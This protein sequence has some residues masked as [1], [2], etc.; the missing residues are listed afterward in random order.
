MGCE[1]LRV[2]GRPPPPAPHPD[3]D[4]VGLAGKVTVS[5]LRPRGPRKES[6]LLSSEPCSRV[7]VVRLGGRGAV[8][9][10][11]V[12]PRDR[13]RVWRWLLASGA[14]RTPQFPRPH[15][16]GAMPPGSG[17]G[18]SSAPG[19]AEGQFEGA[20]ARWLRRRP[21]ARWGTRWPRSAGS[22]LSPF[23][24]LWLLVS[25]RGRVLA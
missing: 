11:G 15:A 19:L 7:T 17:V 23:S 20:R 12:S 1:R 14:R 8:C 24:S 25:A 21:H 10:C 13:V 6:R 2:L 3:C 18:P 16:G 22:P 4:G 5:M 9:A